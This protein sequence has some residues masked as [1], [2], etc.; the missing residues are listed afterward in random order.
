MGRGLLNEQCEHHNERVKDPCKCR[1]EQK[2]AHQKTAERG[3]ENRC[4]RV[5]AYQYR[6]RVEDNR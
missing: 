5:E 4:L 1:G 6:Y 3:E 2:D